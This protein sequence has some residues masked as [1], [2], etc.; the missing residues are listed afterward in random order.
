MVRLAWRCASTFRVTDYA[1]GCNGGRVRMEPQ[2][3]WPVN[4]GLDEPLGILD[5]IKAEFGDSL[6]WADLIVLAG[7]TALEEAGSKE[8]PFCGGRTDATGT[9][10][11]SQNLAYLNSENVV[12]SKMGASIDD[13]Q[14]YSLLLNLDPRE[15]TAVMGGLS[16]GRLSIL[17]GFTDG[18]RTADPA[19]LDNAYFANLLD[20]DWV[21]DGD[22]Y[23]NQDG[24][25]QMTATDILLRA[26]P[27]F[28]TAVQDFAGDKSAFLDALAGAW[29]KIMNADRFDGPTGNLCAPYGMVKNEDAPS[30]GKISP[31]D[32]FFVALSA[33]L[34][35]LLV[36]LLGVLFVTWSKSKGE[37]KDEK[38]K[39][40]GSPEIAMS[41]TTTTQTVR[42]GGGC[43]PGNV[44]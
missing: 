31:D 19:V 43:V 32:Q 22:M 6:S 36:I 14:Q 25:L 40:A 17:P 34:G 15:F 21:V 24:T 41:A 1:G 18:Q 8:L 13:L 42:T 30:S 20:N 37:A 38:K 28:E 12:M 11:V 29:T 3:S 7:N 44:L 27:E 33:G 39:S 35:I 16:L 10:T 26:D 2:I 5:G 4:Q 9:D 23:Q